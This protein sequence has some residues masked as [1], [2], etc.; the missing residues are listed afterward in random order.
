MAEWLVDAS[1]NR[2]NQTYVKGFLDVS[3]S[4]LSGNALTVR[5]GNVSLSTINGFPVEGPYIVIGAKRGSNLGNQNFNTLFTDGWV[6]SNFNTTI[7]L[8]SNNTICILL[9]QGLWVVSAYFKRLAAQIRTY[10]DYDDDNTIDDATESSNTLADADF[11]TSEDQFGTLIDTVYITQ[12]T[13][14]YCLNCTSTFH[15]YY[16]SGNILARR[17]SDANGTTHPSDIGGTNSGGSGSV[18]ITATL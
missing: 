5:N 2:H 12:A 9:S 10:V 3:G 17:I 15:N 18:N 1:A 16:G 6:M 7:K 11:S 8:H 4:D 13:A 14:Y